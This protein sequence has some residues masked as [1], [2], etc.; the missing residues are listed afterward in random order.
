MKK[1]KIELSMKEL[2]YLIAGIEKGMDNESSSKY[3]KEYEKLF[4][5]L[6]KVWKSEKEEE[7]KEFV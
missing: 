3:L 1:V 5:K 6:D 7:L 2:E 4:F